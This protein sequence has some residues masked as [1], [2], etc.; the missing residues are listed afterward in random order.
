MSVAEVAA[1]LVVAAAELE[2][3]HWPDADKDTLEPD[4]SVA[5][6]SVVDASVAGVHVDAPVAATTV[7]TEVDSELR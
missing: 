7:H 4:A 5:D 2:R 6:M 3:S 1:P